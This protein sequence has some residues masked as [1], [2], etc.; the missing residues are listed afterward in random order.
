MCAVYDALPTAEQ[1]RAARTKL[2]GSYQ[3]RLPGLAIGPA[4]T[5]WGSP[6]WGEEWV[7]SMIPYI[8]FFCLIRFWG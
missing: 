5:L 8:A 4:S 2:L 1:A 7:F 3:R 6:V